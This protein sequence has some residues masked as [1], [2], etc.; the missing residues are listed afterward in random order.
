[1]DDVKLADAHH[2]FI[3]SWDEKR[4]IDRATGM[5][6][7]LVHCRRAARLDSQAPLTFEILGLW[8]RHVLQY[9]WDDPL[10][11]RCHDAYAKQGRERYPISD[12]VKIKFGECLSAASDSSEPAALRAAR[13]YL[14]VCFFHP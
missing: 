14:D 6:L 5:R 10:Q 3:D 9:G 13:V 11:F 12:D 4:D 7:A 8:Q 2:E 1:M